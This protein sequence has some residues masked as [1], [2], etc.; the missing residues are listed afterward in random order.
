MPR[1]GAQPPQ[2]MTCRAS[3]TI[4]GTPAMPMRWSWRRLRSVSLNHRTYRRICRKSGTMVPAG[5]PAGST[6]RRTLVTCHHFGG[7]HVLRASSVNF[8]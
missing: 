6:V 3:Y 7:D 1:I 8:A 4:S 2:I 5:K